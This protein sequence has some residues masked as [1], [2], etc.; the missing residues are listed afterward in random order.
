M[1]L[2]DLP[3]FGL[4][5]E[6]QIVDG[7]ADPYGTDHLGI[8]WRD[9][10]GHVGLTEEDRLIGHAAWVPIQ[11]QG[12]TGQVVDVLGLGGV[13]VHRHFRG[14]G[15]GRQVVLAAMKRM[16]E[17]GGSI[18]MLFC[19]SPR[20]SFYERIGWFQFD[21]TVTADQPTGLITMPLVT[22][23]TPLVEGASLPATNLHIQGLPF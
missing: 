8:V 17:H 14:K 5:D 20:L 2:I 22:C 13:M 16:V 15:A 11:V 9:K 21:K 4:D 23:W 6:A 18:G 12:T 7:E 1:K 19:G 3:D 10:S